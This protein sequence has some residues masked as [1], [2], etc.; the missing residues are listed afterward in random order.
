[1][2][3]MTLP[4][5]RRPTVTTPQRIALGGTA[6]LLAVTLTS[7]GQRVAEPTGATLPHATRPR[8]T[9]TTTAPASTDR[10]TGASG[11]DSAS[12]GINVKVVPKHITAAYLTAVLKV[13]NTIGY[14]ATKA[15]Y[16][17]G[18]SPST[19]LEFGEIFARKESTYQLNSI[20]NSELSNGSSPAPKPIAAQQILTTVKIYTAT[21]NCV[22]LLA[23]DDS[24]AHPPFKMIGYAFIELIPSSYAVEPNRAATAWVMN[25]ASTISHYPTGAV[26]NPCDQPGYEIN[27]PTIAQKGY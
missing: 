27:S 11:T 22:F 13:I 24:G 18:L 20:E 6:A 9:K 7:C 16:E 23:K 4:R 25:A 1:M 5:T 21:K 10:T 3:Q 19:S 17:N 14:E 26:G 15:A 12:S 8:V 2:S